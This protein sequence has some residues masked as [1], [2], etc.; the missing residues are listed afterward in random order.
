MT[1]LIV[2]ETAAVE[3]A[4]PTA[5]IIAF[6]PRPKPVASQPVDRLIR[7]LESLNTATLAQRAA[8]AAWRESLS[9]L[10]ATTSGLG[11]SL[12]HYRTS[13]RSLGDSVSAL[14]AKAR[15]LEQWADGAAAD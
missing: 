14:Q 15:S 11:E 4:R 6:P 8:V 13:L 12:Q 9:E 10:Q 1:S 5:T 3:A 7:A 2:S